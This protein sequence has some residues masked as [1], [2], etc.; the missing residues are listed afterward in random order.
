MKVVEAIIISVII[1]SHNP[2]AAYLRR[3]LDALC[4]QTFLQ[5]LW[6]LLLVDN[7]STEALDGQWDLTWHHAGRHIRED[8]LGLTPARL[9]GIG[10][11]RGGMLIFVDD[12]NVLDPDYLEVALRV[13]GEKTFLGAWSGQCR[14]EFEITPPD[15]SRSYF[16]NLGMREFNDDSWSNRPLLQTMPIG[17]GLC[18]RRSVATHYLNLHK[19]GARSVQLDR[20]GQSLLSGGDQDLAA[21]AC[22]IGLGAGRIAALKLTHLIPAER[23]TVDYLVRLAEGVC[24]SGT[25]LGAMRGSPPARRSRFGKLLDFARAMRLKQPHR[26]ILRAHHRGRNRAAD[27]LASET[28]LVVGQPTTRQQL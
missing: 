20:A 19:T 9:R 6:E 18:V 27:F 16:G 10:E 23:L 2:R 12:D 26:E 25:L 14:P 24:F 22:D 17:A 8:Q 28:N 3:V 7:A 13:A 1:C 15:W 11:A 21:C 5:D 4:R